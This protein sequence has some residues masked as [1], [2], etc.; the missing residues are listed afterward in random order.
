[1]V[2]SAERFHQH[3]IVLNGETTWVESERGWYDEILL[4]VS[5]QV[6]SLTVSL[7]VGRHVCDGVVTPLW[8]QALPHVILT[9]RSSQPRLRMII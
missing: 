4:V 7:I 8:S 9:K 1:M 3:R 2:M 6:D 5:S